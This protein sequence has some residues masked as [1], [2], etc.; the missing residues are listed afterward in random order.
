MNYEQSAMSMV[1]E[2]H[3]AYN[4]PVYRK[5]TLPSYQNAYEEVEDLM[6]QLQDRFKKSTCKSRTFLRMKLIFEEYKE[7]C[8][9]MRDGDFVG[10]VDGLTDLRYVVYGTYHEFGLAPLSHKAFIEVHRSNMSKL[11]EDGKPILR[12]DGKVLKGPNFFKPDL[13]SI[14]KAYDQF[15]SSD[16]TL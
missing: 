13:A 9:A 1:E 15:L 7:L 5:P 14:L 2:F 8:E 3:N 4:A 16:K 12:E 10:I 6:N 11:G